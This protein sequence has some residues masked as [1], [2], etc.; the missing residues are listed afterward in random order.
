[1]AT[2]TYFLVNGLIAILCL[3]FVLYSIF[4]HPGRITRPS[5]II[6]ALMMIFYQYP[7]FHFLPT[8]QERM[9]HIE[10]FL[11]TIHSVVILNFAWVYWTPKLNNYTVFKEPSA[12]QSRLFTSFELTTSLGLFTLLLGAYLYKVPLTCTA[13]YSIFFDPSI[14]LLI[15]EIS[16]KLVGTTYATYALSILTTTVSPIVAFLSAHMLHLSI[17]KK[18]FLRA[19]IWLLMLF[20]AVTA[21]LITGAKGSLIPTFMILSVA[22]FLS[23]YVWYKRVAIVI[24]S[25]VLLIAI[26]MLLSMQR[27]AMN[28]PEKHDYQFGHCVRTLGIC[29]KVPPLLNS[30]KAR[31][32]SLGLTRSR[33]AALEKETNTYC[34]IAGSSTI[35]HQTPAIDSYTPSETYILA[36]HE[37]AT[38]KDRIMGLLGRAF[39]TPLIVAQWHFLYVEEYGSPGI[40]GLSIASKFS[41]SAINMPAKVCEVYE[42][43]RSGGDKTSTCT[44]PTSYLFTYPAYMGLMGLALA[45]I[46]SILFDILGAWIIKQSPPP[47]SYLA[48]GVVVIAGINFM[49]ADFTTVMLSHGAGPALAILVLFCAQRLRTERKKKN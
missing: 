34:S 42:F 17:Q 26:L 5:F 13:L 47:V 30:L 43:L 8:F 15:R 31:D 32:F 46:A 25:N 41:S 49:T 36:E 24:C 11:V 4:R 23:A 33:I 22:G 38:G 3:V 19:P 14:G 21:T 28:F 1:M 27:S 37:K 44:A 35:H 20:F 16:V 2:G 18:S 6:A 12:A 7:L 40:Q 29:N 9:I 45:M 10:W 39:L 48:V